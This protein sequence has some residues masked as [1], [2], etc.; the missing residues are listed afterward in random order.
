M[1]I[2]ILIA[3]VIFA[4]KVVKCL[5]LRQN[6]KNSVSSINKGVK[7]AET[8]ELDLLMSSFVPPFNK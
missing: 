2:I 1:E 8:K 5:K 6:S 4:I 3:I 7:V